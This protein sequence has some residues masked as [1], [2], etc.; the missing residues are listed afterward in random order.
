MVKGTGLET[1]DSSSTLGAKPAV[2][3]VNPSFS[4]R[5]K[6]LFFPKKNGTYFLFC[7]LVLDIMYHHHPAGDINCLSSFHTFL[8]NGCQPLFEILCSPFSMLQLGISTIELK[9]LIE[10]F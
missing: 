10:Q 1:M 3:W 2:D 7:I 8:T 9:C 4:P 6:A 5:K